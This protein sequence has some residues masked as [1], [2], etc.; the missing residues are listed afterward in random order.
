MGEDSIDLEQTKGWKMRSSTGSL[1]SKLA[2]RVATRMMKQSI[3]RVLC[4]MEYTRTAEI[5][6]LLEMIQRHASSR[7]SRVLDMGSPQ[8]LSCCLSEMFPDSEITYM[9]KFVDEL[10]ESRV[11]ERTLQL[12]PFTHADADARNSTAFQKETFDCIVSCSVFEHIEDSEGKHGDS[13]ALANVFSWL[14][15]GGYFA[16]SVPFSTK[17]FDEYTRT[18]LYGGPSSTTGSCFFQRFY[19]EETLRNRILDSSDFQISEMAYLGERFF[20]NKPIQD[21]TAKLFARPVFR[22]LCGRLFPVF[23]KI[24]L[25]RGNVWKE[26]KKPYLAFG[27][28]RKPLE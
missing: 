6:L 26:L 14:K 22:L 12:S 21:R 8:V 5:P 15:P 7:P 20:V 13:M 18:P 4:P 10:D 3:L 16:F 24:F 9:N 11:F 28:L 27:I 17:A 23:S 2:G 25:V 19:D 1:A